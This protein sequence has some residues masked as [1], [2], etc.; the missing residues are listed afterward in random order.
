MNICRICC[1]L[2]GFVTGQSH[3]DPFTS[4]MIFHKLVYLTQSTRNDISNFFH[5]KKKSLRLTVWKD[6]SIHSYPVPSNTTLMTEPLSSRFAASNCFREIFWHC[7]IERCVVVLLKICARKLA[8]LTVP[9]DKCWQS[10]FKDAMIDCFHIFPN[11]SFTIILPFRTTECV[12]GS[13]LLWKPW[14]HVGYGGG[15]D[16]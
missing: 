15:V 12:V 1:S 11:S 4:A 5:L 2:S 16:V 14:R 3:T 13:S 10:V 8:T 9:S 6:W 7:F